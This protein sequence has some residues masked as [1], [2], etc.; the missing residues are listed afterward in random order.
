MDCTRTRLAPTPSGYL[1]VGNALN[2][3]LTWLLARHAGG[4]VRL[5][6]DDLDAPR[7]H[8]AYLEDIFRTLEWLGITYDEGPAG[9]D[10]HI[11]QYSQRHRLELYEDLLNRLVET[12]Q[13]FSCTCSRAE[14]QARASDGQ[15][16]GTCRHM[17]LPA[18]ARPGAWRVLTP[19]WAAVTWEDLAL[20]QQEVSV[21]AQMRDGVIRRRDTL[22][23][24]QIASLADDI[25]YGVDL[26]VRGV[27]LLPST[28]VQA[29]LARLSGAVDFGAVQFWHHPLIHQADGTKISKSQ[30]A[31]S[32]ALIRDQGK[33][34]APLIRAAAHMWGLP[35]ADTM[36]ELLAVFDPDRVRAVH[37]WLPE[38]DLKTLIP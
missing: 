6:I 21:W 15:Y 38:T 35:P 12:G 9:P 7:V 5:R 34:P 18:A 31:A 28:A 24:Y 29:W 27:D 25:L 2:F 22:P 14:V 23:A 8:P 30:G 11:R 1:H 19:E 33:S 17:R 26:I 20:G 4:Q 16:P 37:N 36:T 13:V 10:D 32:L 3:M